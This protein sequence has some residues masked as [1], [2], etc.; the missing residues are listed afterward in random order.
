LKKLGKEGKAIHFEKLYKY[1]FIVGSIV[2]F[3]DFLSIPLISLGMPLLF[4]LMKY[5][6]V[7]T[8]TNA[9]INAKKC[10]KF[11]LG[12]SVLWL[13]GY[14]LTWVAKWIIFMIYTN[15]FDIS[16]V[17][18]QISNIVS[19]RI[20]DVN[21]NVNVEQNVAYIFGI[22]TII[23]GFTFM[24]AVLLGYKRIKSVRQIV[25][26]NIAT[27]LVG[28]FPLIWAIVLLNHTA[29]NAFFTYRISMISALAGEMVAIYMYKPRK[30]RKK[31]KKFKIALPKK[32]AKIS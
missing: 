11:V 29:N 27:I 6:E 15:Q 3:V 12:V 14:G 22:S 23:T 26:D 4:I 10:I 13:A 18:A 5:N 19:Q 21:V 24:I 8:K 30:K 32:L 16:N 25:N 2:N 17:F 31:Q 20:G 9:R 1:F 28:V 7:Q